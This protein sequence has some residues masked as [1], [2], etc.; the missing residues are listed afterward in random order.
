MLF[1]SLVA[2]YTCSQ[3]YN[4]TDYRKLCWT[5]KRNYNTIW[6][7]PIDSTCDGDVLG[8]SLYQCA[9]TGGEP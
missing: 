1:L 8:S 5:V 2:S 6:H 7:S 9:F 4:K 3:N